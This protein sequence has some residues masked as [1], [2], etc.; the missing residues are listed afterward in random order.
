M[1]PMKSSVITAGCAAL[2]ASGC[3]SARPEQTKQ[4]PNILF[5]MSDDHA[6]RAI[7]AYDSDLIQTPNIDRLAQE[8]VIFNNGFVTNSICSPSRATMLTSKFS[9][10]NGLR[11]NRDQFDG[12]QNTWVKEL[13]QNGYKTMIVGKWHLK[14]EPQG[15][16]YWN[17]LI[18][19][20][21]YYNPRFIE[22]GDTGVIKGYATDVITELALDQLKKQDKNKPFAMLV[23]HKAPHRNWMPHSKNLNLF[24]ERIFEKPSNFYDKYENR[25]AAAEQDLEINDMFLSMDF[26]LEQADY[27]AETG[28]GGGGKVMDYAN[29]WKHI[30]SRVEGEHLP[31]WIAHL[32]QR[33]Q[34]FLAVKDDPAALEDWKYQTY[35]KDYLR[36]IA[37][38]DESVGHILDYLDE[39]G[40]A[41]NTI[42]VYTSD[43]GFYLGEHGWYDKR[44]MYKESHGTPILMRY[45]A[46]VQA[47]QKRDEFVMNLDF[48][49]TF[50]DFSGLSIPD[51][52]QGESFKGVITG[53]QE[54][55]WR[56]SVYYHYYEYPH[57]WHQ[58]KKHYGIRRDNYKLIHFYYDIDSWE[59]YDLETDPGEV[60]NLYGQPKYEELTHQLKLELKA[61]QEKYKDTSMN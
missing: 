28:S 1:V 59:L 11:D 2:L 5:I 22:N 14:T 8:G 7:S 48:G 57:G 35:L 44:F 50:L 55:A 26:K 45:P 36:C 18:D 58:V 20:G 38:V 51:E 21:E 3:T 24:Q 23:H 53:K 10:L 60:R 13:R 19:Q 37:S 34:E 47:H 27:G 30:L 6:M 40:F 54:K 39:S 49:P 15:F 17:I 61:L 31:L 4:Q 43:Q 32:A 12:S 42:V 29:V 25:Q 9:H 46:Q 52:M 16:D 56:N 33:R 41:E